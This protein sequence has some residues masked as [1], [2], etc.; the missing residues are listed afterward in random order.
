[1]YYL[2]YVF[3]ISQF[4][5]FLFLGKFS[6]PRIISHC[7]KIYMCSVPVRA[8]FFFAIQ[9]HLFPELSYHIR[10]HD[11]AYWCK[12]DLINKYSA[13]AVWAQELSRGQNKISRCNF[14]KKRPAETCFSGKTNLSKCVKGIQILIGSR[15]EQPIILKYVM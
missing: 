3:A 13:L 15:S 7:L 9:V 1:M 12:S 8:N 5:F 4:L 11:Q 6:V 14:E 10:V 2:K